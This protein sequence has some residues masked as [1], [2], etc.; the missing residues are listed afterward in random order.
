[1][2]SNAVS[3]AAVS[4]RQALSLL[5]AGG[6]AARN[7]G[8]YGAAFHYQAVF[9]PDS[10]AWYTR[11]P[12]LVTGDILNEKQSRKLRVN[13]TQLIAYCWTSAFYPGDN[14][15][16]LL[17]WQSR[18]QQHRPEWLLNRE[19]HAG[20]AAAPGR[21]A[22]WYD[23]GNAELVAERARHL[24]S[25]LVASNY[26]GYFFDTL[27]SAQLPKP[28][29]AEFQRRHP[30]QDYDIAQASLLRE[31]RKQLPPGRVIFTNQGYRNPDAFL[32]HADLDLSESYFTTESNGGTTFRK[33]HD[34]DSP[35]DSIKTPVERLVLP[36]LASHPRV[37][38]VHLNYASGSRAEIQRAISYSYA[39]A[40]IFK[41]ESYL[42]APSIYAAEQDEVY[43]SE[44]GN[45]VSPVYREQSDQ[46]VAWREYQKGVVAINSGSGT[47]TLPYH[48]LKLPD[49]PRGYVFT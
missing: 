9:T 8:T 24:A 20:G 43:F 26:D 35:W 28:M 7:S 1:M 49:P 17:G 47:A 21:V 14:V 41:H 12:I 48:G 18:V 27:G 42:V 6:L 46:S 31:L 16:A 3:Q 33:W 36:A 19:P 30:G 29:L 39:C 5:L 32:P 25:R 15:S 44:L 13:G 45:P 34:P 4:R 40:R 22:D 10:E 11:F 23:F 37:R 38:F 2:T